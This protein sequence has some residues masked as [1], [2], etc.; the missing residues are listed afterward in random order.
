MCDTEE[1]PQLYLQ[2]K[3]PHMDTHSVAPRPTHKSAHMPRASLTTLSRSPQA[4]AAALAPGPNT[5]DRIYVLDTLLEILVL[6]SAPQVAAI[7]VRVRVR[8]REILVLC[9]ALQVAA[10]PPLVARTHVFPASIGEVMQ[11]SL[12]VHVQER[13]DIPFP[14]QSDCLLK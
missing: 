10:L 7:R 14:P 4:I 12:V 1:H 2:R 3:V 8:V 6:C 9:S 5:E 11:P 13:T